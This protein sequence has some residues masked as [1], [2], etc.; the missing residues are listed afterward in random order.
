[1]SSRTLIS[2]SKIAITISEYN[3]EPDKIKPEKEKKTLPKKHKK[4]LKE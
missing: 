2:H 3:Q 1:M 4:G